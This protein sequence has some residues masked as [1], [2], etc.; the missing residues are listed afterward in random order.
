MPQN[1]LLVSAEGT[2]S[3]KTLLKRVLA[4]AKDTC[5]KVGHVCLRV[6][7]ILVPRVGHVCLQVLKILVPRVNH[8]CLQVLKILVPRGGHV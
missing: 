7:K 6:L 3:L 1:K 5:A 8:V 4:S 2:Q